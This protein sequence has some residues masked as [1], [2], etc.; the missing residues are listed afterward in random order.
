MSKVFSLDSPLMNALNKIADIFILN[1]ITVICCIPIFTIGASL[2]AMH[3]VLLKMVRNE[4]TYIIKT[5]FRSFKQNFKQA[6]IIWLIQIAIFAIIIGDYLIIHFS[7]IQFPAWANTGI[8]I[9][10]VLAVAFTINT[11][12]LLSKFDN[13]IGRT[14]KN[15]ILVGLMIWPKTIL[16]IIMYAV[17]YALAYFIPQLIPV[18][19]LLFL[20]GPGYVCAL[21]YNKTFKK[22]EPKVEEKDADEWTVEAGEDIQAQDTVAIEEKEIETVT[23]E[24]IRGT[25]TSDSTEE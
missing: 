14:M 16:M 11:F 4:E 1:L 2:T 8:I 12:P 6:T 22:F 3:F 23:N 5:F 9:V 17:P 15:S 19:L 7:G 13:T 18:A 25:E 24:E 10:G 20:S 21:L